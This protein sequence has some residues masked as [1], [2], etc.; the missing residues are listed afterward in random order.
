VLLWDAVV[1][2][3]RAGRPDEGRVVALA[4]REQ[5]TMARLCGLAAGL[6]VFLGT[7]VTS[8]GP[9]GGDPK[10]KRLPY[11]LHD[12][13]RLH[14]IAAWL[15]LAVTLAT[16][17]SML[18]SGVPA[19]VARRGEVVVALIVVQGAVGYAQYFSGVPAWLV[20][21]HLAGAAAVWAAVIW[22]NTGLYESHHE[23]V[24]DASARSEAPAE[25]VPVLA[26]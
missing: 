1:L 5:V 12:V 26:G 11:T 13:A 3:R 21:I 17:W 15:F 25:A 16:L 7:V 23:P 24:T 8:S 18:R 2:H 10:A 19:G 22:F 20:A 9:H 14:S 6:T 4:G